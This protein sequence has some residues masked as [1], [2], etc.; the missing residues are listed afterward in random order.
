MAGRITRFHP[1]VRH[2]ALAAFLALTLAACSSAPYRYEPLDS[3]RIEQRAVVQ[4]QGAFRVRASVPSDDEAEEL[5]GIPLTK[6]RI[7]AVWLEVENNSDTRARFAPYSVDPDY[8]PPHEVAYMYRK[9]F[10]KQGWLDMESRFFAKSMP[11]YIGAGETVSGFVFTNAQLGTKSF[12]VDLF[13]TGGKR[14]YEHFT[15]FINVPG[16][17]PDHA[18]V[19]FP[20]LYAADG[21]RDVDQEAFRALLADIPCCTSSAEGKENGQ[22]IN[23]FLVARGRDLLQAL[24]RAGWSETSYERND[25]Y[26]NAADYYLGRPPDAIFR[27][28]RDKST[29]RNEMGLWLAPIRVDGVPVWI[30]Q[31]KH[32]IGQRYEIGELFLGIRLDPDVNDGRNYLMQDLWYSQALKHF[33][34]SDTGIVVAES[35][36]RLDY[37][38]N[39]WFSDGLRL[40]LWVSGEP[41]GLDEVSEI[42]WDRPEKARIFQQP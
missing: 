39:A 22:P 9:Q 21:V 31:M 11:R 4:E 8:F 25:R 14:G 5:F 24:L 19:D 17:K 3:F 27:K 34:W 38:G 36:P 18:E 13:Y 12:N 15:F 20:G 33:A 30:A 2:A 6:R 32:A 10:S 41:I 26:L 7:Q 42:V 40:A 1:V 28:G 16:F 29:E 37:N 35:E 23:L